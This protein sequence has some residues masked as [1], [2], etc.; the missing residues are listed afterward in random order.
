MMKKFYSMIALTLAMGATASAATPVQVASLENS[1]LSNKVETVAIAQPK[2]AKAPARAASRDQIVDSY[3]L[4]YTWN[5]EGKDNFGGQLNASIA[6][7]TGSNDVLFYIPAFKEDAF[8]ASYDAST[9]KLRIPGGQDVYFNTNYNEMVKLNF[10]N[11]IF[12]PE[13]GQSTGKTPAAYAEATVQ[14]DGTIEFDYGTIFFLE[15][16]QGYFFGGYNVVLTPPNYFKFDQ[17]KWE[18]VGTA[19]FVDNFLNNL[20]KEEY[21]IYDPVTVPVMYNAS[22]DEYLLDDPYHCGAW[23]EINSGVERGFIV[24][25]MSYPDCVAMR[26]ATNC[27]LGFPDSEENPELIYFYPYNREGNYYYDRGWELEDIFY[28]FAGNEMEVSSYDAANKTVEIVNGLFGQTGEALGSYWFGENTPL[29]YTIDM[30]NVNMAGVNNVVFDENA[31][32][33]YFNLQGIE[34]ANPAKGQVVIKTQGNKAQ[35]VI[36]K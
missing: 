16:S 25:N 8:E 22:T 36:V 30:S 6:A 19:T 13:T 1:T 17:S 23:D 14:E 12:D 11:Y 34:V 29:G 35:K 5:L 31:P 18:A 2:A 15:I 28:D 20:L 32:V 3:K 33:K 24:F 4:N 27:G 9:G 21:R 26:P 7:G 10:E